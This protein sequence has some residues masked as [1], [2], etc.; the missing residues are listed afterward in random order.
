[1]GCGSG[2]GIMKGDAIGRVADALC[3]GEVEAE[4]Q[5]G[6]KLSVSNLGIKNRAVEHEEFVI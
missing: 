2:S 4:L 5:G 3:A 6:R 1:V